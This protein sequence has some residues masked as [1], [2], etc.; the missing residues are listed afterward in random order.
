MAL[1]GGTPAQPTCTSTVAHSN[2]RSRFLCSMVDLRTPAS[3]GRSMNRWAAGQAP[4]VGRQ[5][6]IKQYKQQGAQASWGCRHT[7][8]LKTPTR[9]TAHLLTHLFC[10]C[11][12]VLAATVACRLSCRLSGGGMRAARPPLLPLPGLSEAHEEPRLRTAV[13]NIIG[14]GGRSVAEPPFAARDGAEPAV[15]FTASACAP[16]ST[17]CGF[18]SPFSSPSPS[19]SGA[20]VPLLPRENEGW[21]G[22]AAGSECVGLAEEEAGLPGRAASPTGAPKPFLLLGRLTRSSAASSTRTTATCSSTA[23]A[24]AGG[25]Q[26]RRGWVGRGGAACSTGHTAPIKEELRLPCSCLSPP[27]PPAS[28]ATGAAGSPTAPPAGWM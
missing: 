8:A 14:A 1:A 15:P 16:S 12:Q 2:Q 19:P 10:S 7:T 27:S 9:A 11:A 24:A 17:G 4:A 26:S 5:H 20:S 23:V 25:A 6:R 3:V 22:D 21:L 18:G 13:S 28:A